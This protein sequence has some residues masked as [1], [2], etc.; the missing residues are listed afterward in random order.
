[1]EWNCEKLVEALASAIFS[2]F[3]H[4][5]KP[6]KNNSKHMERLFELFTHK[7][8]HNKIDRIFDTWTNVRKA[9]MSF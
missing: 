6:H 2:D 3:F 8:A 1:M 4:S 5:F 9:S 7:F